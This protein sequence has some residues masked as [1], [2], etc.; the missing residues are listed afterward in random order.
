VGLTLPRS[1]FTLAGSSVSAATFTIPTGMNAGNLYVATIQLFNPSD[2]VTL[3]AGTGWTRLTANSTSFHQNLADVTADDWQVAAF[4]KVY[5]S[6]SGTETVCTWTGAALCSVA[7]AVVEGQPA[8][9]VDTSN[10]TGTSTAAT[11]LAVTGLSTA[12][13]YEMV[14]AASF[15][16]EGNN[17]PT[18]S[19]WTLVINQADVG[20]FYKVATASG[21]IGS[22]TFTTTGTADMTVTQVAIFPPTVTF[23]PGRMPL[24]A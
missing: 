1:A 21:A 13:P 9:P 10:T 7:V 22:T 16:D 17:Y 6:G 19:G 14:I 23:V 8:V 3:T 20:L 15:N 12:Q 4:T 24:G 5:S 18:P 2:A 11:G